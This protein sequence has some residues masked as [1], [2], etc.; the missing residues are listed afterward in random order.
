MDDE[1]L[2]FYLELCESQEDL[3]PEYMDLIYENLWDMYEKPGKMLPVYDRNTN[4]WLIDED[5]DGTLRTISDAEYNE[6]YKPTGFKTRY[7]K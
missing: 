7:D 3:S 2:T 1:V 4:T 6:K 5:G